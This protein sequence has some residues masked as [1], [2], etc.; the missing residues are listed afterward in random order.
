M[1]FVYDR[2]ASGRM[3]KCLVITDDATHEA[4]AIVPEHTMGGDHLIRVLDG[5][6]AQRRKPT[7]IRSDNVLHREVKS[8]TDNRSPGAAFLHSAMITSLLQAFLPPVKG[9]LSPIVNTGSA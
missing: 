1:H 7:V 9:V 2:I 3:L 8:A 4:V 5:I 6:C